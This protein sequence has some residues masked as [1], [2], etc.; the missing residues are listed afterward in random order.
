MSAFDG[1]DAA[2]NTDQTPCSRP[3]MAP[4]MIG[5]APSL[6]GDVRMFQRDLCE[7]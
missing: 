4:M 6:A 2:T 7:V 5:L 1:I 3:V